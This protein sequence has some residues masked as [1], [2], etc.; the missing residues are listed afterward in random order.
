MHPWGAS[1]AKI[2]AIFPCSSLRLLMRSL[3]IAG[4]DVVDQVPRVRLEV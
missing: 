4:L 3:V 1:A 2:D